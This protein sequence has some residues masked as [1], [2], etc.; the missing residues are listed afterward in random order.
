LNYFA[1][2]GGCWLRRQ[3]VVPPVEQRLRDRV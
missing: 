1:D 2:D 3:V